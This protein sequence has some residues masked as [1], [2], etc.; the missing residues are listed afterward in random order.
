MAHTRIFF[1]A[2]FTIYM[3]KYNYKRYTAI[4]Q[5]GLIAALIFTVTYDTE[6][7]SRMRTKMLN[8]LIRY[9]GGWVGISI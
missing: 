9:I 2:E 5:H 6:A 7:N 1:I 3:L 8:W 4:I